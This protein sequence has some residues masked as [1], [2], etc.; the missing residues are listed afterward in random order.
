MS[1]LHKNLKLI[2]SLIIFLTLHT[3][4]SAAEQPAYKQPLNLATWNLEWLVVLEDYPKLLANCDSR[5]QPRSDEWRFP[6]DASHAPPPKRSEQD[7]SELARIAKGLIGSVVALQEV[8]GPLAAA[9]VFPLDSWQL[10][11]FT[12]RQHPQKVGF[13]LPKGVPYECNSEFASLDL[14]GR[15]RSGAD[16]T[17][18]PNTPKAL[19]LLNVHLKSGCFA[20][21]LFKKGPCIALRSQVPKIEAW[22]DQQVTQKQAFAVLGDFNRRLEKDAQYPAGKDEQ[23]PTSMFAAWHDDKPAGALLLRA[24]SLMA[25]EPCSPL[26]PY[27]QGAID[28]VLVGAPWAER[29]ASVRASR[30]TYTAEQAKRFRLSDHCPLVMR[31]AQE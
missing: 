18:W 24:T 6:C 2:I 11:C 13:A 15:T 1:R 29:F 28:N 21:P 30:I 31:F 19:R 17:L 8:D 10:V 16:I 7:L 14:D 4:H 27:T 23:A 12:R 20:G 22:I 5:G 9:Q 25:D 3:S 26:S